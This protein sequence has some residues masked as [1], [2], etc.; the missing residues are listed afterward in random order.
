[1]RI[2]SRLA[3]TGALAAI[4]VGGLLTAP[5]QGA[6]ALAT[7]ERSV[8]VVAKPVVKVQSSGTYWCTKGIDECKQ[9]RNYYMYLGCDVSLIRGTWYVDPPW[10][11][12][13]W[14]C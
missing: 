10:Y 6:P 11:V 7:E 5:V 8:E 13:D 12:F 14:Y 3:T 1:M 2:A 4:A 9:K